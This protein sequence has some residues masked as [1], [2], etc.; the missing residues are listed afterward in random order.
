M[1][2][3]QL[4]GPPSTKGPGA[5]PDGI[6]LLLPHSQLSLHLYMPGLRWKLSAPTMLSPC[7][8]GKVTGLVRQTGPLAKSVI[9]KLPTHQG[10]ACASGHASTSPRPK[11]PV[12]SPPTSSRPGAWGRTIAGRAEYHPDSCSF[13]LGIGGTIWNNRGD[14]GHTHDASGAA[15]SSLWP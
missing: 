13:S 1:K 4:D 9:V 10:P 6:T 7:L 12:R 11:R 15:V 5:Q 3:M 14:C 8:Y 2:P